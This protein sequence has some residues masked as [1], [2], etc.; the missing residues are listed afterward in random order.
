[1]NPTTSSAKGFSGADAPVWHVPLTQLTFG[2][3]EEE[4]AL[5]VLRSRW[6]SMGEEVAAFE[7]EFAAACGTR[8]AV[9]LTNGTAALRVA[10]EAAGLQSGDSIA[11]PSLTFISAVNVALRMGLRVHLLD[12]VSPLDLTPT[13]ARIEAI[14]AADP[15]LRAVVSMPYGGY[16]PAMGELLELCERNNLKLIEDSCHA[17]LGSLDGRCMGAWGCAGT[18]SFFPNKNMTTGEGGVLTTNDPQIDHL[19][20]RIRSH[21]MTTM[22]LLRHKGHA[23]GYDV[24][25]AGENFRMD[26]LRA[27]IGRAQ[28]AKVPAANAARRRIAAAIVAR[29]RNVA[30]DRIQFPFFDGAPRPATEI[31]GQ[32]LLVG[33]LREDV[34]RDD[35]RETLRGF[36][37]Q[38][39]VHYRPVYRFTHVEALFAEQVPSLP[40]LQSVEE[41]LVTLPLA[42]NFTDAQLHILTDAVAAALA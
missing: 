16:A 22:T 42:P 38:T 39:S 15:K 28:L 13:N 19:A 23:T 35:F 25:L 29:I 31:G 26:E 4:A 18:F 41:R 24:E 14:A 21:G 12:I 40:V 2:A 9:A 10:Y 11:I 6:L 34:S 33:L 1:M 17:L 5:R 36:G 7:R 32:H 3:E 8:H 30:K 20:R 37:V 27:A